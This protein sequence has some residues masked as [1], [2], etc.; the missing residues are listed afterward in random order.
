MNESNESSRFTGNTVIPAALSPEVGSLRS[1]LL[2]ASGFCH[3][4]FTRVGGV[5]RPPWD[6]LNFAV[7]VGDDPEAVTENLRRASIALGVQPER[8][9]FLSQVH[10]SAFRALEGTEAWDE[11]V[12]SVGDITMS[13][14]AGVGCGVRTADCV[15]VLLADRRS[16]AVAAVHSGWRGTADRVV[17]TGVRALRD[18]IGAGGELIAAI[19]PHIEACCFEVG[20]DVARELAGASTAGESAV[21]RSE[22]SSNEGDPPQKPHVDLRRIV[23]AQLEEAGLA[24]GSIDDVPGCT[25]CHR[26]RFHS[27]R[28]DRERSGRLLSAIVARGPAGSSTA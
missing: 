16:G 9:Y 4:F 6:S 8:L 24:P 14:M 21:L 20:E 12:R 18:L 19:G 5:S 26:D 2:L 27:F 1:S 13:R 3:A 17:V 11:V 15:P 10:G 7:G 28:R 22:T 23:R 25:V